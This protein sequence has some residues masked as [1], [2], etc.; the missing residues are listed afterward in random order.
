M[1]YE[2]YKR[3]DWLTG[4]VYTQILTQPELSTFAECIELVGY[5]TILDVSGSYT[6]FAPSNEAWTSYLANEPEYNSIEDLSLQELERIVKYHIIQNAWSK[7][8]LRILDVY[9]WIDTLDLN[10][11]KPR[12]FKRE[13]L[14]REKNTKYGVEAYD[15]GGGEKSRII[16]VDT[17]ETSWYRKVIT[18]SRKYVPLFYKEYFNIYDLEYS[19]YG[20]Y[21][22]RSFDGSDEIYFAGAK[23]VS[24]EIFAENGFVYVV[25][26]VVE[27]LDNAM[28]IISN[29]DI[30]KEYSNFLQLVNLF[31]KFEYNEQKTF[32]Q[33][34]ADQGIHVDS[35]FDLS[36]QE[37]AFD[38]NSE[39]TS[40]PTGTYGLPENVTVRYHHGF[41]APTNDAFENFVNNYIKIPGGWG[42]I[43]GIPGRIKRIIANAYLSINTIY[44]S[45]FE[46]GFYNGENDI[47][48]LDPDNITEKRFGSNC[49]FI[50]LN[51]AVV[52]RAFKS[53]T[54][55]IY[56]QRGYSKVMYAIEES[57]LLST[58]KKPN[59]D[60]MFFVESDANTSK[61]SSFFYHPNEN[62]FSV[63]IR[64]PH[65][66]QESLLSLDDLR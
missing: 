3:P 41:M 22:N 54:G 26:R 64:T 63:I 38:I 1:K 48:M 44:P 4:K 19:D 62:T 45:D 46:K 12:G 35:L 57:G 11:N 34:G 30:E 25:D 39:K 8:Q 9:G 2:K 20:F 53:V 65:G 5:D 21:F 49:S 52:P 36:F 18:D 14:L 24:D 6:V 28:E 50:G 40:P 59:K 37:L 29:V 43:D 17:T 15:P 23:I 61:D 13:T 58:L 42:S 51:E 7:D 27:P 10:N 33:P 31:P 16:I 56:L 47:V 32:E 66:A 55:P 60:Y